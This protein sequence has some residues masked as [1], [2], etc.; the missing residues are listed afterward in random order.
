MKGIEVIAQTK[1][2]RERSR[3]EKT[4]NVFRN[5]YA[6]RRNGCNLREKKTA[7]WKRREKK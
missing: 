4:I 3:G 7:S 5:E 6:R 2:R 1:G